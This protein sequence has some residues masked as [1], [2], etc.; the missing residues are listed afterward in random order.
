MPML[1][2]KRA[3]SHRTTLSRNLRYSS[4]IQLK[5]RMNVCSIPKTD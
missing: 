3:I 4:A 1:L 2:L 5:G